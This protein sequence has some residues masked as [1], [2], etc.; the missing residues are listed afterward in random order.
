M[1]RSLIPLLAIGLAAC[2]P[3][4]YPVAVTYPPVPPPMAEARPLPPVSR[5]PLIWQP[6]HYDWTGSSYV[7]QPGRYIARDVAGQGLWQEGYRDGTG[8]WVPA[9]WQ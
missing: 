3:Q 2:V 4:P 8:N 1:T 5:Q 9:H 6:G 7:W